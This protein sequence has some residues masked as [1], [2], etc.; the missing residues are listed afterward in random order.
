MLL[1][2]TIILF[3]PHNEA[4]NNNYLGFTPFLIC[5][6]QRYFSTSSVAY[7]P[8]IPVK[9]YSNAD[10]DKVQILAENKGK[11]GIYL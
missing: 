1:K 3:G 7:T 11:S 6:S 9:D 4:F 2:H 8:I 10:L 5:S